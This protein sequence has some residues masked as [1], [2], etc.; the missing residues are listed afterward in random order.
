MD[1]TLIRQHVK[2]SISLADRALIAAHI[3]A[4]GVRR[5]EMGLRTNIHDLRDFLE[6]RGYQ[7]NINGHWR[8]RIRIRRPGEVSKTA[9]RQ[10]ELIALVDEIRKAEGKMPIR[11]EVM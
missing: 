5:F 6:N 4:K 9:I 2:P 1:S 8:G 11:N 7:L 10:S 3:E